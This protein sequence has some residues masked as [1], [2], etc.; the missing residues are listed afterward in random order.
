MV[1]FPPYALADQRSWPNPMQFFFR[2]SIL[3]MLI[4]LTLM[5]FRFQSLAD[6]AS[7][8]LL[9][10]GGVRNVILLTM[11]MALV[12]FASV[13]SRRLGQ[14]SNGRG[15]QALLAGGG[16][17]ALQIGFTFLKSAIPSVVP[18]YADP[19]LADFDKFL[20]AGTDPWQIAHSAFSPGFWA[21]L[22]PLYS[23]VWAFLAV[24]LPMAVALS[25]TN[26]VRVRRFSILFFLVW[27]G[28]G[29]VIALMGSSAGPIFYDDLFHSDRFAQLGAAFRDSGLN[30]TWVGGVQNYLWSSYQAKAM[31]FGSGISAFPS[32]HVGVAT[33]T[34][35]YLYERHLLLAFPGIAF[36]IVIQALSVYTGFHYAVDGYFSIFAVTLAWAYLRYSRK[37]GD[38]CSEGPIAP[39]PAQKQPLAGN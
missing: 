29:N 11:V 39:P 1:H 9:V 31:Y 4:S 37:S 13:R 38:K 8:L 36:L 2:F 26:P 6:F 24:C 14:S 7:T 27:I 34:A 35:L 25:D 16:V 10:T 18:F 21:A 20:H 17:V 12:L 30:A 15:M 33:L 3:Y 22:L 19:A 23:A 28:L 32:V 5:V